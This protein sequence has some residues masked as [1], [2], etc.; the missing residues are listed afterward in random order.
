MY[1]VSPFTYLASGLLSTGVANTK[2]VCASNEYVKFL[3][4]AGQSCGSYMASYISSSGGYLIGPNSTEHCEFCQLSNTNEYLSTVN[5]RYEDRWRNLGIV[6]VYV[7][8]N[9]VGALGVYWLVRVPKRKGDLGKRK[10]E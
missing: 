7:V 2:I 9:A 8:V 1:Y 3:P 4:P 5:I 10:E 6:L